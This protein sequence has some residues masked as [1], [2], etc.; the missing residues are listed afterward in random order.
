MSS[1]ASTAA[2][3]RRLEALFEDVN[4]DETDGSKPSPRRHSDHVHFETAIIES[5]IDKNCDVHGKENLKESNGYA[6]RRG[7]LGNILH[8][9]RRNSVG[10]G[11]GNRGVGIRRDSLPSLHIIHNHPPFVRRDS[12]GLGLPPARSPDPL[13]HPSTFPTTLRKD[14]L[15][16]SVNSLRRDS[17][18]TFPTR[19]DSIA[20]STGNL[21]KDLPR[22][23]SISSI[24]SSRKDSIGSN[25][26]ARRESLARRR[27]STDSLE[28]RRN[29]WDLGRRG[30]S[31][32]SGGWD[33]PI[34]EE[35]TKITNGKVR[36]SWTC[37][38]N[39]SR[40]EHSL[41]SCSESRSPKQ[42][43]LFHRIRQ[44]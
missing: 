3:V 4:L 25:S 37:R 38:S 35:I 14:S 8:T 22:R 34:W 10:F 23:D 15:N 30:S 1:A 24:G 13:I 43:H 12:F 33:D 19:R 5:K 6:N 20:S 27:F 39:S 31:S 26:S 32:S 2:A 42:V 9:N 36:R 41:I 16:S 11:L 44:K 40:H 29:S 17:H 28:I 7:S 21:R 18:A